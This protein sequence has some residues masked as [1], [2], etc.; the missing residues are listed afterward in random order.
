MKENLKIIEF[1]FFVLVFAFFFALI[2]NSNAQQ[3]SID[4]GSLNKKQNKTYITS[5]VGNDGANFFVIRKKN[6]ALFSS[7]KFLLEKFDATTLKLRYSKEIILP[8]TKSVKHTFEK[9]VL[10][11]KQLILFTS[12]YDSKDEKKRA[13]AWNL[14]TNASI[15]SSEIII[16][17]INAPKKNNSGS[18]DFI[19]SPDEKKILVYHNEP[20]QKNN[21]EKFSCT[22]LNDTLGVEYKKSFEMPYKDKESYIKEY[23][24]DNQGN[25]GLLIN[26]YL[27]KSDKKNQTQFY[28]LI[29]ISKNKTEFNEYKL[30]LGTKKISAVT[31]SFTTDGN[32]IAAGFFSNLG[33]SDVEIAGAFYLKLDKELGKIINNNSKDFDKEFLLEFISQQRID[34]KRELQD[35]LLKSIRILPNGSTLLIGEK[36][37]E[38]T[39]C[40]SDMRTGMVNCTYYFYYDDII[41][42]KFN[43]MGIFEW[44]KRIPKTQLSINDRGTYSSFI[45]TD[46]DN[47]LYL[48]FNDNP[49]NLNINKNISNAK[50]RVMDNPKKAITSMIVIAQN[51]E[52]AKLPLFKAAEQNIYISPKLYAIPNTH[53]LI[54]YGQKNSNYKFGRLS[55]Q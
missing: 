19:L 37:E 52:T 3:I 51:G 55:F 2:G 47:Q 32:I 8:Q 49:T 31:F 17:E 21:S 28:S 16:D 48:I 24:I 33:I 40:Y 54:I 6:A 13:F 25:I 1:N 4:W 5:F 22:L 29:Y 7:T 20:Y 18:F 45:V 23:K 30:E 50:P 41:V 15:T 27:N 44:S 12:C 35:F 38:S 39:V 53:E 10:L 34:K 43:E 42:I 36:Y 14:S 11:N 9:I 46:F 26:V